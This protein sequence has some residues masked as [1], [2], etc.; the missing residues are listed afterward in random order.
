MVP[1][2]PKS[3]IPHCPREKTKSEIIFL[4]GTSKGT[5]KRYVTHFLVKF[6]PLALVTQRNKI[7]NPP[8]PIEKKK[9]FDIFVNSFF[10]E[11]KSFAKFDFTFFPG[12]NF[13]EKG[14]KSQKSRKVSGRKNVFFLDGL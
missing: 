3:K 14:Q 12:R 2:C 6:Q 1:K 7:A 8:P 11:D 13:C 10:M 4:I 9:T 5:F